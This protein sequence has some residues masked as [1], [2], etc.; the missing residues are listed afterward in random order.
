LLA[1]VREV[2][3]E[4]GLEAPEERQSKMKSCSHVPSDGREVEVTP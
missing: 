1:Y 4:L 2:G 3:G